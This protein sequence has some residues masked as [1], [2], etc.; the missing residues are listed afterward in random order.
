LYAWGL[1]SLP[2]AGAS[3]SLELKGSSSH[4]QYTS[5]LLIMAHIVLPMNGILSCMGETK[6]F[7]LQTSALFPLT[8]VVLNIQFQLKKHIFAH[9]MTIFSVLDWRPVQ[10][11]HCLSSNDSWDSFPPQPRD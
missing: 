8:T 6:Q 2:P 1:Y 7:A 4:S 10:G 3:T 9:L 5:H 11:V